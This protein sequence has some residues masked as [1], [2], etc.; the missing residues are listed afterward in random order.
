[1][2]AIALNFSLKAL[3]AAVLSAGLLASA[4]AA[5]FE[6]DEA[7]RAIL[8][9]RQRVDGFQQSNQRTV[10]DVR[11]QGE[12]NAQLRRS[13]LELQTQIDTL[14]S[15]QAKLNGQN[16]QL[17]RSVGELQSRQKD[18]AQGV[19]ER[20]RQFEPIKVTVD[21]REFQADPA[22]K[23]DFEAAMAVF[24]S[25]KFSDASV[26]FAGFVKQY[27]RSGYVP[28]ARF[29]LGNA[30]YATREY[31]DAIGNFKQM[32]ADAPS[33]ARAPEAA[34][35]IANCQIELKDTR[36]AR[37]TLEDLVRAYPQSEAAMAAK[38]RL[39]RLK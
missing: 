20:L 24:R 18:I 7:R 27:P 28:S 35:S 10:D 33:H 23:R 11:K 12:E 22:E 2:R 8:E 30:Q 38:E 37:K 25:G 36:T 15:D 5:L 1:M 34:L 9:M 31:K 14:K 21:G 4:N 19:D 29:W 3:S 32:L 26:A 13:L 17:L 39:S 6:D 16:E